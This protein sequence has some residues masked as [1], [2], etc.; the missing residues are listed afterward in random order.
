MDIKKYL[1]S[2]PHLT[3]AVHPIG[4]HYKG[5]N[6]LKKVF[7]KFII[8]NL[9]GHKTLRAI[10]HYATDFESPFAK[11]VYSTELT[12]IKLNL[13]YLHAWLWTYHTRHRVP[14][15][16]EYME[17]QRKKD[18]EFDRYYELSLKPKSKIGNWEAVQHI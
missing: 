3:K 5:K 10:Q 8:M 1:K 14:P 15:P 11:D 16:Q 4:G 7:H 12:S 18:P 9:Y 2:L 13:V 17:K 6:P